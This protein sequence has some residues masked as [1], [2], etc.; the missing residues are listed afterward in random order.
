[1]LRVFFFN[2]IIFVSFQNPACSLQLVDENRWYHFDDSHVSSVTEAEIKS[3]AAYVLFYQRVKRK[4][5]MEGETSQVHT[6]S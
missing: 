1:M 4:I 6:G 2:L 5:N 3:S